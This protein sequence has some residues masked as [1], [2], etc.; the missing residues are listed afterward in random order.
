VQQN[1]IIVLALTI[2]MVGAGFFLYW[3]YSDN[4]ELIFNFTDGTSSELSS[5][6][7]TYQGKDIESFTYR[8]TNSDYSLNDYSPYFD[9]P[10]G[11]YQLEPNSSGVWN[12]PV[13]D[14]INY[15]VEDGQ[16]QISLIPSGQITVD[17][18]QITLP[19][20]ITFI[21]EVKDDRTIEL[22]FTD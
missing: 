13:F 16:Y 4:H 21:V 17:G 20:P 1:K 3:D 15:N 19:E 22:V 6:S 5:L 7:I 10:Q 2:V 8:I 18:E 9:T 11:T 12:V 14:V